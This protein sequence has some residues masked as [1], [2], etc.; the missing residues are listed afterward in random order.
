MF[1]T[2]PSLS[3]GCASRLERKSEYGVYGDVVEEMDSRVG[4][5]LSELNKNKLTEKTIV[6]FM[7]DNGPEPLTKESKAIPFRGKKWSALR[8]GIGFP[9]SLSHSVNQ[10]GT[11]YNKTFSAMDILPSLAHACG[12]HI[13]ERPKEVPPIDGVNLW[14]ELI[15]GKWERKGDQISC[16]GMDRMAFRPSG[17][18]PGNFFKS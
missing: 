1:L 17:W 11:V 15:G 9:V 12:I 13:A 8:E 14:D 18:E 16:F 3:L 7:S 4:E 2:P 6:V 10:G 5:I